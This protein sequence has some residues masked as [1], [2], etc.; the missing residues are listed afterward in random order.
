MA[1][2]TNPFNDAHRFYIKSL[3]KRMLKNELDWAV[4]YDIFRPRALAIRAEFEANR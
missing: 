2:V 3:Y 4:R 1:A